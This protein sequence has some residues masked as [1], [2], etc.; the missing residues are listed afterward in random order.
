[1]T[2]FSS[3]RGKIKFYKLGSTSQLVGQ[4][5]IENCAVL[6]VDT[7]LDIVVILTMNPFLILFKTENLLQS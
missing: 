5:E 7:V 4:R 3:A 1:M 2:Q 6:S